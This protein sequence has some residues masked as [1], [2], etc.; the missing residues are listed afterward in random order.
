M[1]TDLSSCANSPEG[2]T[3]L[4]SCEVGT[5]AVFY[6]KTVTIYIILFLNE[7]L[8][9]LKAKDMPGV[10]VSEEFP[11]VFA[12]LF[13]DDLTQLAETVNRLQQHTCLP[14]ITEINDN[15]I[16]VTMLHS[17]DICM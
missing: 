3:S 12:L 14:N 17:N 1:Y 5:R 4:F 9:N 15:V 11:D 13:A 6:F 8:N 10:Q 7:L 16:S 2:V